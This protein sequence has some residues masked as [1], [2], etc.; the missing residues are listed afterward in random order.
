MVDINRSPI[1][2]QEIFYFNL[3]N[4]D[5]WKKQINQIVLVEENKHHNLNTAPIEITNI[6]GKKGFFRDG[7]RRVMDTVDG[8]EFRKRYMEAIQ[9]GIP[10]ELSD[11]ENIHRLLRFELRHAMNSAVAQSSTLDSIQRK[12]LINETIQQYTQAGMIKEAKEYL[13]RMENFSY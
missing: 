4:F 10:V 13:D 12:Q 8:K 9:S 5:Q 6:M 11:F 3:P 7:I 2:T 1:F